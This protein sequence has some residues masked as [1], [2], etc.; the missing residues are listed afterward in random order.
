MTIKV[1]DCCGYSCPE[2]VIMARNAMLEAGKGEVHVKVSTAVARDNVTRAARGLGWAAAA[3][4]AGDHFLL[5]L[6]R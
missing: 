6:K 3:Q 4:D 2:P 5:T 1:V